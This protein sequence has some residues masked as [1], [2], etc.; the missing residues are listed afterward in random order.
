MEGNAQNIL[1]LLHICSIAISIRKSNA[2]LIVRLIVSV[3]IK[4]WVE[5]EDESY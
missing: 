3:V 5:R 2:R 4:I 1:D